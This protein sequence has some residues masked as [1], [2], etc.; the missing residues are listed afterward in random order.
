MTYKIR[1]GSSIKDFFCSIRLTIVLFAA[2]AF[3]ALLG[4]IIPQQEAAEA[5]SARLQPA[6]LAVFQENYNN[7][8]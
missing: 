1:K 6:V 8:A 4:T 5:F 7:V 2:I 3:G